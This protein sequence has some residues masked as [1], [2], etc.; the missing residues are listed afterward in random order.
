MPNEMMDL[1]QLAKYLHRD[2]REV[3]KLASRG[4]QP[5]IA[6]VEAAVRSAARDARVEFEARVPRDLQPDRQTTDV[7]M[8]IGREAVTNAVKHADAMVVAV[9]L[10]Y[11][12]GWR[13]LVSDEGCGFDPNAGS[14]GFGLGSMRRRASDLGGTLEVI[15]AAGRGTVVESYLP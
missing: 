3:S 14:G 6:S 7:L 2:A 13:L 10:A 4:H 12:D 1:E 8:H 9:S 15:S 11:A 5:V